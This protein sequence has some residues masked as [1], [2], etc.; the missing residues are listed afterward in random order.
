MT[1]LT[2]DD[3]NVTGWAPARSYRMAP[4]NDPQPKANRA[5]RW[6]CGVWSGGVSV[7]LVRLPIFLSDKMAHFF[8]AM[9]IWGASRHHH[10]GNRSH[11][12]PSRVAHVLSISQ[13]LCCHDPALNMSWHPARSD[14]VDESTKR[15]RRYVQ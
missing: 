7:A 11:H 8:T 5:A 13:R 1:T 15:S 9:L 10:G 14:G 4:G 2:M 12:K 3:N 6:W